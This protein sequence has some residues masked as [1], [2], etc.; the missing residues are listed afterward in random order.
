MATLEQILEEA[1]KLPP[2][3]QRRLRAALNALGSN[4]DTQPAYKTN[5]LERAW[6]NAHRE[7]YLGQW[8]ALDGDHLVAHGTDA[9]EVYDQA[10]EQGLTAPYL[11]RV[12]P[13]QE[14]FMGGWQ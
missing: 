2:E 4:G 3:E 6:I 13:K 9:K 5:E 7:E 14:A 8:V 1:K 12:S 11:E 10:R